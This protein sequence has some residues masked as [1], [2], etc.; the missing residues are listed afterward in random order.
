MALEALQSN[1]S[2]AEVRRAS[3][4]RRSSGSDE[5]MLETDQEPA[6]GEELLR[7]PSYGICLDPEACPDCNELMD[8][9]SVIK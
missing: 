1:G 2:A 3:Q 4:P 9:K 8:R 7:S 6:L 5:S